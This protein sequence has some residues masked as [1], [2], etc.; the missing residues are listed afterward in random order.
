MYLSRLVCVLLGWFSGFPRPR[1]RRR[2]IYRLED[3]RSPGMPGRGSRGGGLVGA[4]KGR[5]KEIGRA[6]V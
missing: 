6:H 3:R 4:E 5:K 2:G 1:G